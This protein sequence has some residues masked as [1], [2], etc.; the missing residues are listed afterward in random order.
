MSSEAV[1]PRP[2]ALGTRPGQGGPASD[3]GRAPRVQSRPGQII[4]L[5][6]LCLALTALVCA[7]RRPDKVTRP[8]FWAEDAIVFYTGAETGGLHS[9]LV[10]YAGYW[11]TYP[12]MVAV[13]G[14]ALP[15]RHLPSLYTFGWLI[16]ATMTVMA[17]WTSG[18][19]R[20]PAA[21]IG[22]PLAMLATPFSGEIWFV[23]TNAQ[24]VLALFLVVMCL[25][26]TPSTALG[27]GLCLGWAAIASVTGPFA[28][29]LL[30]SAAV[31]LA[32]HR[33]RYAA[34][35][36]GV[37]ALGAA[38]TLLSLAGHERA[39]T[40]EPMTIRAT[41]ILT[42]LGFRPALTAFGATAALLLSVACWHGWRT[43]DFA[44]ACCGV[45]GLFAL[46]A[47]VFGTPVSVLAAM[48]N[49]GGRY[50]F[51][52]W[53]LSLW[54]AVLLVDRGVRAAWVAVVPAAAVAVLMF[55]LA[56]L[57][58]QDWPRDAAC[59][60]THRHCEVVVNPSWRMGLPGRG[61]Q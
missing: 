25:A 41:D 34:G 46:G 19:A 31:R 35:V 58:I 56:P 14:R 18:I 51:L 10:P 32:W 9:L 57:P 33:D 6:V 4:L 7:L 36:M 24:W 27:K 61:Q 1:P 11:N 43:R 26:R 3:G 28:L 2:S 44:L 50:L 38:A 47:T 22:L 16:A 21:R 53:V 23:L 37:F 12:R 15:V 49:D 40:I 30:P 13:A 17:L 45:T 8:Q 48:P 42:N 29:L 52:P 59:L 60:E 39:G 5:F 55:R 54:A 20:H